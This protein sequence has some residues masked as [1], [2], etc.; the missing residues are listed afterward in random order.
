M[1]AE[2]MPRMPEAVAYLEPETLNSA[3]VSD[4][5]DCQ[6]AWPDDYRGWFKV[7]RLTDA[8]AYGRA[9]YLA[10]LEA[11]KACVGEAVT[12]TDLKGPEPHIPEHN[13]YNRG[14]AEGMNGR[15]DTTLANIAALEKEAK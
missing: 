12:Y 4:F 1:N 5:E 7:C 14:V 13:A 3:G 2:K 15:R 11:A 6:D 8:E 9:C 10:G